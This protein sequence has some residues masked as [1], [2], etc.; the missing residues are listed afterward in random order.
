VTA[1]ASQ[2]LLAEPDYLHAQH[3]RFRFHGRFEQRAV[4]WHCELYSLHY[5]ACKHLGVEHGTG[6]QQR[7]VV[8]AEADHHRI[9][10][11]LKLPRID[12]SAVLKTLI[13]VR[14][15]KRLRRGEHC[16]GEYYAVDCRGTD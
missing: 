9:L 16:Y 11:A 8:E 10:V 7:L 15:Y 12:R 1:D 5:Y 2:W 3:A 4:L 14:N 13:M 6:V